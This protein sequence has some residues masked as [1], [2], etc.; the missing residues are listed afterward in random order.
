MIISSQYSSVVP[1]DGDGKHL[2]NMVIWMDQRGAPKRL[3]H[4]RGY[5]HRPD[6]PVDMARWLRIHGLAPI[7]GGIGLTDMRWIK[8]G[9][10]DVYARTATLLEPM[11]YLAMRFSGRATANQCTAFMSL[12]VDNRTLGATEYHPQLV[13]Q[14]LIDRASCRSWSRS[15]PTSARSCPT[16]PL[17]WV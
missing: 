11:D 15:V 4:V 7:D 8:Y 12:T 16:L 6:S 14:S 13:E 10:P 2:A 17:S 1:V 5:R 9:R 3:K